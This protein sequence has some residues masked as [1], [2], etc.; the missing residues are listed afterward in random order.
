MV[1]KHDNGNPSALDLDYSENLEQSLRRAVAIAEERRHQQVTEE[2]LLLALIDDPDAAAVMHACKV[3]LDG[4]RRTL[5]MSLSS[6]DESPSGIGTAPRASSGVRDI[7]QRAVIQA[8][9]TGRGSLV[10]GADMLV[11][12]LAGPTGALL[13]ER[14]MTRYDATRYIS[15]GIAK[16]G[17]FSQGL[18][19][20]EGAGPP[21]VSDEPSGLLAE[22]RLLNDNYTPMEFVVHVLEQVFENDHE[23]AT[24]IMLETHHQG[25]GK[26]GVY[27]YDTANAK[28]TEVFNLAREHQHPLQCVLV[29]S[30]SG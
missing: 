17:R 28:V 9:S 24:R 12:M 8:R 23:S 18:A 6:P 1:I 5:S 16:G 11:A 27:P 15:H 25:A 13:R 2:N 29:R 26:C 14:G 19:G 30:R 20:A 10:T 3:D 7:V 22:V 21:P 4:L